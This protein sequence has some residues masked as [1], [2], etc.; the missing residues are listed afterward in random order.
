[1]ENGYSHPLTIK[2][3]QLVPLPYVETAHTALVEAAV[4][5]VHIMVG[6]QDGFRSIS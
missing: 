3:H 5:L 1:M 4:E 2:P 6:S